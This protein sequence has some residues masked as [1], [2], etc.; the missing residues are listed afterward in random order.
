[1]AGPSQLEPKELIQGSFFPDKS[2]GP[3][4]WGPVYL[5]TLSEVTS[6]LGIQGNYAGSETTGTILCEEF[7]YWISTILPHSGQ[8]IPR[9]SSILACARKAFSSSLCWWCYK[10]ALSILRPHSL[11]LLR[12]TVSVQGFVEPLLAHPDSFYQGN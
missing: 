8:G 12:L 9:T 10:R 2:L 5:E 4:S 11:M 3:I 7:S 1:M 6:Y